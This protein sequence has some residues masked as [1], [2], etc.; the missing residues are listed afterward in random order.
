MTATFK[1]RTFNPQCIGFQAVVL[2]ADCLTHE[3]HGHESCCEV[4]EPDQLPTIETSTESCS[5]PECE[6]R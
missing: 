6:G 1:L 3:L 4:C 5:S 2:C